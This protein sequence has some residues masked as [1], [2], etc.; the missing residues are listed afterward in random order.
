MNAEIWKELP[1]LKPYLEAE[2]GKNASKLRSERRK[3]AGTSTAALNCKVKQ[4]H[5][6]MTFMTVTFKELK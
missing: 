5:K 4:R 1:N 6:A 2:F 3:R